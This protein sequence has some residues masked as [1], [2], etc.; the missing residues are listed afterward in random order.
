MLSE[1][2]SRE[3]MACR[4]CHGLPLDGIS[5]ALLAGL[6]KLRKTIGNKPVNVSSAYRCE[7]NNYN[8]GG[9]RNSQHVLGKAADIWVEGYSSYRLGGICEEIFDGVGIY[10]EQD[11]VHVDMRDDGKNPGKYLWY[12]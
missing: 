3:E 8:V 6:E 4:C 7:D 10:I 9:V 11:F 12:E 1:H 5:P 2:F